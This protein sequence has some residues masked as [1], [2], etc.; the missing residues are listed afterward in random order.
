MTHDPTEYIKGLQQLLISDKKRIAFLFGAG[1]SLAKKD[2]NKSISVPAISEITSKIEKELNKKENYKKALEEIKNELQNQNFAY[3]IETILSNIEQKI[4]IIGD[5]TLN[6]LKEIDFQKLLTEF[7]KQVRE[8]VSVHKDVLKGDNINY[9]IHKDF[10]E[11]IG[12]SDRKYPVEIFTTNYD[13]LFELGLEAKKIPY[14]DGFT[15]SFQPFFNSESVDNLNFISNQTKLWKL[16]GSLGW[17]L[18]GDTKQVLRKDSDS[19]D[20]LIYP[21]ILKYDESKKQ[22]YMALMD[23]LSNFLQEPDTVLITCGYSFGDEHINDR[24]M[25]ALGTNTTA[26][27]IALFYDL[28]RKD[29]KKEYLLTEDSPLSK[30][31]KS[32]GKLSVFGCKN[33]VIGGQYGKWKLKREPDNYDTDKLDIYFDSDAPID[34]N[35][36][37]K[38][39]DVNLERK[40]EEKWTG[41]GELS[42]P[43]FTKFVSFLEEMIIDNNLFGGKGSE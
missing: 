4:N 39:D 6:G 7:K 14:Y 19:D 20:I 23:R 8:M 37:K 40:G 18:N 5:G 42:L 21:S 24:I 1:T 13:Y 16:H 31:A 26:H 33:A 11:W 29:K 15:G 32:N 9:L 34:Q 27:V 10:A 28:K 30:L 43:D 25:T 35:I 17:H 38:N 22:P 36:P 12:K 3:N 2:K 41:E